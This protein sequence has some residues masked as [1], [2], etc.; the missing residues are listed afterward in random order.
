MV[1]SLFHESFE[2]IHYV[3][4]LPLFHNTYCS[5]PCGH[6]LITLSQN[7]QNL[8]ML[9]LGTG[10]VNRIYLKHQIFVKKKIFFQ[11]A[12]FIRP[13][14]KETC[15]FVW[16]EEL[17]LAIHSSKR[18]GLFLRISLSYHFFHVG[19]FFHGAVAAIHF[20]R[21]YMEQIIFGSSYLLSTPTF[22]EDVSQNFNPSR[23]V[24]LFNNFSLRDDVFILTGKL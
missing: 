9:F 3:W 4:A 2:T 11:N 7:A 16:R 12:T 14:C 13:Y 5:H 10:I 18:T 8:D 24:Y 23:Q 21:G 20:L 17:G 15:N 6:W 1:T 19:F 22:L